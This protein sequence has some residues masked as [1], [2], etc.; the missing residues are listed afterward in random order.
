MLPDYVDAKELLQEFL[1]R[2]LKRRIQEHLGPIREVP[3]YR[4]FE[5]SGTSIIRP[6]NREDI[7]DMQKTEIGFSVILDEVPTMTLPEILQR[8]DEVG[9]KMADKMAKLTY[10]TLS[11]GAEQ[12]GNVVRSTGKITPEVILEVFE[13]IEIV[14]DENGQPEF[15]SIHIHPDMEDTMKEAL[16]KLQ[17]I[18][19]NRR[20]FEEILARK[21]EAW[22][23]REANRRLVG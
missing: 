1:D 3:R 6:D 10:S 9:Q 4:I 13:K 8:L 17:N 12:V 16:S 18:P 7:T 22:R 5:G 21:R 14:F 23:V 20:K 19:E 11:E 2:W 15:P